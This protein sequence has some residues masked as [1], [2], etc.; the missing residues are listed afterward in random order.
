MH[1]HD[2]AV[3]ET[4]TAAGLT[5][6]SGHQRRS[7]IHYDIALSL[8]PEAIVRLL[9]DSQANRKAALPEP[10]PRQVLIGCTTSLTPSA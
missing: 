6:F 4:A 3:L 7:R 9:N 1:A 8:F 5:H 2:K 10:G